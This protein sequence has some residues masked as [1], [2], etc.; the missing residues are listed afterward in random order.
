VDNSGDED[1]FDIERSTDGINFTFLGSVGADI[2]AFSDN[3]LSASTTYYYQVSSYNTAGNSAPSNV[4]NATTQSSGGGVIMHVENI[5]VV[6][7][8]LN[9]RRF[10]A[11][12][13]ITINDNSGSAVAGATVTGDFTGST[14]STASGTTNSSGQVSLNSS[15]T[16]NPSGE[17]CF[18]VTDVSLAGATYN[19]AANVVTQACESGPKAMQVASYPADVK[20]LGV[21]PNPIQSST[22]IEFRI[23]QQMQVLVEVYSV[24]GKRVAVITD[25]SYGEG[26]HLIEWNTGNLNSGMYFLN[27]KVAG[28]L[29]EA[30]RLIVIR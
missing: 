18:E 14:S 9:G 30:R 12:A 19:S 7:E 8:A 24:F 17:W 28:T 22:N 6:R 11:V 3:G 2:V 26:Q 25:Q 1:G 23:P 29:V 21:Y 16:K 27:L 10:Q 4:A 15:A 20:L 13:T 5:T